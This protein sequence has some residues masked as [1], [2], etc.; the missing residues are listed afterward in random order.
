MMM[1]AKTL[2]TQQNM[3]PMEHEHE[4]SYVLRSTGPVFFNSVYHRWKH[5]FPIRR[6]THERFERLSSN[7]RRSLTDTYIPSDK[8]FGV[9][10]SM[11]S[12]Y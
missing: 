3:K 1:C 12:W 5:V 7:S 4:G 10:Y 2:N 11:G 8:E 9:H 6:E